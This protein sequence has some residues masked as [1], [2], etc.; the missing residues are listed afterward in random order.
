M[1]TDVTAVTL[2]LPESEAVTGEERAGREA[3]ARKVLESTAIRAT[4]WTVTDY[5]CS[6]A[7][8]VVSS[9]VLTR[10]LM[11]E[12]FGLMTLVTTLVVGISLLSDIGLGPSVIQSARGDDPV[13]LNTA[14]T[15]QVLRGVGIF[16]AAIVLAW[17]M[18][19]FYHDPRLLSLILALS[20]TVVISGFNST[21]LLSLSRHMGVRRLFLFDVSSQVVSLVATAAW[22]LFVQRSVWALVAGSFASG[23]YRLAA[24][25]YRPLVP[26]I[27]NKLQWDKESSRALV[28]FGK[29]ILLSTAFY[30]FAS[31]ADRLILG[32]L[33]SFSLLGV[34]GIAY[35]VSDIPRAIIN[36][37]AQKVGYPFIAK[38]AHLPVAE[39]RRIFLRYR[40][41]ALLVGAATLCLMVHLGGFLVTKMYDQRYHAASWMVP[42]LALGLWHTMLYATTMPALFSLGK[43]HYAAIG[44]A[45]YCV[46]VVTAIPLGFHFFGMFGAVV[47]VAAGDLPLYF[48]MVSGASREGV[49][50]WRQDLLATGFFL[51]LLGVGLALRIAI[52]G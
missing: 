21:N 39:F 47:A 3:G 31:Q 6:M 7:L 40:F 11:P 5:G 37:F 8:R 28:H 22:A 13:F 16:A 45:A 4:F 51:V 38:M 2:E 1:P 46:S 12:S 41:R 15:L 23:T 49:S 43:S 42:V 52:A 24:S 18:S 35:S 10:L 48:V 17:P 36:A 34:Y 26:G 30:F 25:F 19:L 44:N 20:F 33:I 29:W 9:L 32:K 27:R 14:W 50:T